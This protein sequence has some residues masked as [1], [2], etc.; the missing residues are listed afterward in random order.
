LVF[1]LILAQDEAV[2]CHEDQ[3][4]IH[5]FGA[6]LRAQIEGAGWENVSTGRVFN[7]VPGMEAL[8]LCAILEGQARLVVSVE[9]KA[10]AE[11]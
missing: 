3:L 8:P 9:A 2:S 5:K 6:T 1:P 7:F 11:A 4:Q 10:G